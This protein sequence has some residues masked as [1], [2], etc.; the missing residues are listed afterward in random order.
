M[1]GKP[2]SF[3]RHGTAAAKAAGQQRA[4]QSAV[5]RRD[6]RKPRRTASGPVRAGKPNLPVNP[7][8]RQHLR[9]PGLEAKLDPPPRFA[10]PD[11]RGSGKLDGKVALITGG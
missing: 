7:L 11:Y 8:P 10:A 1:R 3:R 6:A 2:P 9:K 5:A 4:L